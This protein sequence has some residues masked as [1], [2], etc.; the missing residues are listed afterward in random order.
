ME[1]AEEYELVENLHF[2]VEAALFRQ[3]ADA[4][5]AAAIEGFFKEADA[6]GVGH[7]DA[8]HHADGAGFAGAIG[9]EESEH[10]AG[11]DGEREVAN[12]DFAVISLGDCGELNDRHEGSR[13]GGGLDAWWSGVTLQEKCSKEQRSQR[14]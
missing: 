11:V 13:I 12:G 3:V 9:A 7:G 6:A 4:V 2:L 1:L 8:H 14:G 5:E 10:L